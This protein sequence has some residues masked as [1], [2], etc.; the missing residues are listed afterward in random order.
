MVEEMGSWQDPRGCEGA[1]GKGGEGL[2]AKEFVVVLVKDGESSRMNQSLTAL[3]KD[4]T[5]L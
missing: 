1:L 5:I 3:A 4:C 2:L